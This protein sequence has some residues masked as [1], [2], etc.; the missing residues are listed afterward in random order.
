MMSMLFLGFL[1]SLSLFFVD[2]VTV[3]VVVAVVCYFLE[4]NLVL[5]GLRIR[6]K[7]LFLIERNDD[8]NV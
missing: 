4:A 3:V 8:A 2:F 5:S 6:F 1:L 7:Q